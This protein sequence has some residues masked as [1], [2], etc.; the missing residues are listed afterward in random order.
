LGLKS[1]IFRVQAILVGVA[2]ESADDRLCYG[3]SNLPWKGK[4]HPIRVKVGG[5]PKE[6]VGIDPS[7]RS[8]RDGDMR[9]MIDTMSDNINWNGNKEKYLGFTTQKVFLIEINEES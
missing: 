7:P 6:I 4:K 5:K 1:P 9:T 2:M 8:S 3:C